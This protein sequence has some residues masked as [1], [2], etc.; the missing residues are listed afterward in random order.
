[1][2]IFVEMFI[3]LQLYQMRRE[4]FDILKSR[5]ISSSKTE[6][7]NIEEINNGHNE[8]IEQ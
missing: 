1:M 4:N 7:N 6:T 5:M 3:R 8:M 2:H